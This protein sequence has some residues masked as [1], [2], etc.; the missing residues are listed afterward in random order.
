VGV[1][2]NG[3]NFGTY[4]SN[5]PGSPLCN[6]LKLEL[7]LPMD[8]IVVLQVARL[9]ALKD[10][11]T[12]IET[13]ARVAK[14]RSDVHLVLAGEGPERSSIEAAIADHSLA[15]Q[16]H[17]LGTRSDIHHLLPAADLFLLTSISEGIPLTIIEA[18]A[19]GLP[20]VATAVGGIPEVVVDGHTGLL[21]PPKASHDLAA[22]ILQLAS[23]PQQRAKMGQ[24][25]R[26]RAQQLFSDEQMNASYA[27]TYEEI[28][29]CI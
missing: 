9:D 10:H 20:V 24:A 4:G 13:F 6:R 25:G 29:A 26:S 21:T 15:H 14:T 1:I 12:A 28:A 5:Q 19:A 2:Y 16:V 18:M 17:L 3:V 8:A 7:S 22:A 27:R 11:Q 23:N